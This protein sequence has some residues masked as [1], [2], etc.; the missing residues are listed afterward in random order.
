M[1]WKKASKKAEKKRNSV[2]LDMFRRWGK[3]VINR[4]FNSYLQKYCNVSLSK[5]V[6][7]SIEEPLA[8]KVKTTESCVE[9]SDE[10][11]N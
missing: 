5:E 4:A 11:D 3:E 1:A 9:T 8:K 7:E 10:D 2:E 6:L